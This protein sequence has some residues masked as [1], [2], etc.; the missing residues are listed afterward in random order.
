[1]VKKIVH[2]ITTDK[3]KFFKIIFVLMIFAIYGRE[4]IV[5]GYCFNHLQSSK[6]RVLN[7][8][9]KYLNRWYWVN[10]KQ[11]TWWHLS[12]ILQGEHREPSIETL[13][14]PLS[15]KFSRHCV[16]I[17]VTQCHI[18]SCSQRDKMKIISFH[19]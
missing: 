3:H 18:L 13:S 4:N 2:D 7:W 15:V 16:M 17:G 12:C 14:S 19:E 11:D 10:M 9:L 6:K 8:P 1:M 5:L